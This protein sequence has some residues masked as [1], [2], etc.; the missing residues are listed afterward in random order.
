MSQETMFHGTTMFNVSR[1]AIWSEKCFFHKYI[2]FNT[3]FSRSA[4]YKESANNTKLKETFKK[5]LM[6]L[7]KEAF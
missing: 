1:D 5:F 7:R 2:V 4:V 6:C 3:Y